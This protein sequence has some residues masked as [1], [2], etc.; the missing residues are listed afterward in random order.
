MQP[1]R[2]VTRIWYILPMVGQT[3]NQR[4][5]TFGERVAESVMV[6]HGRAIAGRNVRHDI[7]EVDLIVRWGRKTV[8]IEVKTLVGA[9][10]P[11][12]R[13]DSAKQLRLRKMAR[14]HAASGVEVVAVSLYQEAVEVRWVPMQARM[15]RESVR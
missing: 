5:G 6:R 11:F 9:G 14:A 10:N 4:I 13:I 15:V 7:G 1:R 12:A 3:R 2:R 8:L